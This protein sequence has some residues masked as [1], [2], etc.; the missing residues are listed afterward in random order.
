[1]GRLSPEK[2]LEDLIAA[3]REALPHLQLVLVGDTNYTDEYIGYL[4]SLAGP[5]VLFPGYL[6]GEALEELYSSAMVYVIPSDIE[7]LSLSLL[8]AMA[9]GCP[10]VASDIPGNREALGSP[11]AGITFPARDRAALSAALRSL[12][13]D[14]GLRE[15]LS[16]AASTRA[17][18]A[19][20]W[21]A[22]AAATLSVYEGALLQSAPGA[23]PRA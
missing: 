15:S 23:A 13:G 1:M 3:H 5:H 7:G 11:P 4:R 22:I 19:F 10:V 18:R 14:V 2:R 21:D 20:D 8:E 16:T 12:A 6:Q 17:H 9:L